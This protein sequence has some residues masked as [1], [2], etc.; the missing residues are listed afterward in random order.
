MRSREHLS[1]LSDVNVTNLVDVTMVLLIIFILVSPF[2]QMGI[3]VKTP[4]VADPT[5]LQMERSI[6]V[7]IDK[8]A[9]VYLDHQPVMIEDVGPAVALAKQSLP[10]APV[11]IEADGRV[12]YEVPLQVMDQI[13]QAGV[14]TLSLVTQK[15]Q[16]PPAQSPGAP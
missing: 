8:D 1:T 3:E 6:L 11:L 2:I 9:Q 15:S 4:E 10:D 13:R 16:K 7:E 12:A 5:P 14:T